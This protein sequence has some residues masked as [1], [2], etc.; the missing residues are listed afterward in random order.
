MEQYSIE[1]SAQGR[2]NI[3]ETI[4]TLMEAAQ[5]VANSSEKDFAEMKN[6]KWYKRLWEV[7][8][9]SKNNQKVMAHGVSNLAKLNEIIM[10][11]IVILA[12]YSAETAQLVSASLQKIENLEDY[13]GQVTAGLSKVAQEV[14]KL[15]YNYKRSLTISDLNMQQRDIVGSIFV[16]YAKKCAKDGIRPNSASQSLFAFVMDGDIPE[17]DI[18]ISTHL[19]LLDSSV[20]QLLY[21]LNQSYYYLITNE[22]DN[23][24]YFDDF[25]VSNKDKKVIRNQIED[26]VLFSGVENYTGSLVPDYSFSYTDESELE[27]EDTSENNSPEK[28]GDNALDKDTNQSVEVVGATDDS[29]KFIPITKEYFSQNINKEHSFADSK[30][31]INEQINIEG[32]V[33]FDN[34]IIVFNSAESYGINVS[35]ETIF[36]NCSFTTDIAAC[37]SM[38]YIT[39]KCVFDR[40]KFDGVIYKSNIIDSDPYDKT[41]NTNSSFVCVH[42][43]DKTARVEFNNCCVRN[44]KGTF[45]NSDGRFSKNRRSHDRIVF[46]NCLIE[47]HTGNYIVCKRGSK[48][49]F[50]DC[51]FKDIEQ[52]KKEEN[53]PDLSHLLEVSLLFEQSKKEENS[54]DINSFIDIEHDVFLTCLHNTFLNISQPI[55]NIRWCSKDAIVI[56]ECTF[57]KCAIGY[58][59]GNHG[60]I[61]NQYY[62]PHFV[63]SISKC[64][65][66]S[67][68]NILFGEGWRG[69]DSLITKCTFKNINTDEAYI[70]NATF[71]DSV[72]YDS[73]ITLNVG[74]IAEDCKS[75]VERVKFI[76]C[77]VIMKAQFLSDNLSCICVNFKD[78]VFEGCSESRIKTSCY[79]KDF[80]KTKLKQIATETGT[81]RRAKLDI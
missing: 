19:D 25:S 72:F 70:H 39:G 73:N 45:I 22:F 59:S 41:Q 13:L 66:D 33:T 76:E 60:P 21:R 20:Q 74:G 42:G 79:I 65:F 75:I 32:K 80:F 81:I 34:C 67:C 69:Y 61:G 31:R 49:E 24:E 2:E 15:K 9:F 55:F 78:C 1:L 68:K 14:K 6:K 52:L 18:D 3:E 44:C 5:A 62:K 35:G 64:E 30:I 48:V 29:K 7:I 10:K 71:S 28:S 38:I 4:A 8:T 77:N 11:A 26:T 17:N 54:L 16:K 51:T 36:R 63:A 43:A 50:I 23:S 40:C 27:F 56:T 37:Y 47:K 46:T 58:D 12:K 57:E 53:S